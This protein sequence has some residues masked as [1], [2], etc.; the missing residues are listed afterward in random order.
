MGAV[1]IYEPDT[2]HERLSEAQFPYDRFTGTWSIVRTE[3]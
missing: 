3:F 1:E 2:A